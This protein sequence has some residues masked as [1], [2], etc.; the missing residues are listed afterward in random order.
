[1]TKHEA[2]VISAYT[3]I[4]VCDF[5]A[6]QEYAE[7]LF[8]RH[9]SRHDFASIETMEEFKRLAEPDFIKLRESIK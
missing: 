1:M 3:G 7:S 4:A 5:S 9:V 2:A 6:I 8:D